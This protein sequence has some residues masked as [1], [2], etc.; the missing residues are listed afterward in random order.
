MSQF[1]KKFKAICERILK[2]GESTEG[3]NVRA[4]WADGTSAHTLKISNV[5]TDYSLQEEFPIMTVRKLPF[6]NAVDEMLWIWS[7]KSNDV[8]KLRSHIWDAW[9]DKENTIGKAYGYQLAKKY[10]YNNRFYDQ[11][12]N[13]LHTLIIDPMDR[14]MIA[15]MF[16]PEELH[17]MGLAPCCHHV[18][19][20]VVG[21][22][23]DMLL[24]QRS[25]DMAV[26][27]SWNV[28]QYAVLLHMF[29]RHAGLKANKLTHVIGDCHIYERHIPGVIELLKQK[30]YDAPKLIID[31][32]K[33]FYEWTPEDFILEDYKHSDV[34]IKFEVAT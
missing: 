33:G 19:L 16:N 32:D 31:G 23:L 2:E 11:V 28:T 20:S 30:E 13:L 4:K 34:K 6:I 7:K 1:D 14:R 22:K 24:K 3:Y 10:N 29:A 18:Q 21:D 17:E 27:N 5:C 12:D 26:A 8:T 15:D 9:A 25:Q